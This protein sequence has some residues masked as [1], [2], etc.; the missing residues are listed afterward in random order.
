MACWWIHTLPWAAPR[1]GTTWPGR[2]DDE[3]VVVLSTAHPAKFSDIVEKATGIVPAMPE[4][5]A[6]CLALPK[7]AL[8]VGTTLGELSG[9][10]QDSFG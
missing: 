5:L 8:K 10:L 6:R 9:F 7:Q 1:R 2:A 4:R 3:Q